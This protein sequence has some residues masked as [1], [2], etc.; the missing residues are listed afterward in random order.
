MR[1]ELSIEPRDILFFRD[2]R[3]MSGSAEGAGGNWPLPSVF[4][5]AMRSALLAKWPNG[6]EKFESLDH[7][8][9]DGEQGVNATFGDL[10]TIGP[11]PAKDSE[12]YVP[13]PLDI[14]PGGIMS[15]TNAIG[16]SNLP[17]PLK[18][19]VAGSAAPSKKKLGDWISIAQ[20]EK[21]LAG[22]T[23][24][25]SAN[26]EFFH[27]E[28][29]PGVGIDPET[30]SN[31][32]GKFYQAQYLRLRPEA[33]MTAFAECKGIKRGQN[34]GADILNEL[35]GER[36]QLPVIFG[37]QRGLAYLEARRD[38]RMI[39]K[40]TNARKRVKWILLSPALFKDGWKPGW[41]DTEGQVQLKQDMPKRAD[42]KTR[43]QWR[44][45]IK[46]TS[47]I[48]ARLVAARVGKPI[49][50]SGWKLD[51][52]RDNAGGGAKPTRL[53]V[54]AG[55]VYY[56]ECE[57]ETDAQALVKSLHGQVKSDFLGE[58]GFG[59][60]ICGVWTLGLTRETKDMTR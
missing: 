17:C 21:Y 40:P 32:E 1:Y 25:T 54:P 41:L 11:F 34:E 24:E 48:K 13:T 4:Y 51:K 30:G 39:A 15:P 49:T 56:F 55:S 53:L 8:L 10:K 18:Y 20:L 27:P 3:P 22:T 57:S 12:L 36:S 7:R 28:N 59:F 33:V 52:T 45:A 58:K 35:F 43:R 46:A 9:K 16:T 26:E 23:P 47:T 19:A 2:A 50:M 14:A 5:S 29:R 37:G 42:F 44:E 31:L 60:G 38:K 6:L